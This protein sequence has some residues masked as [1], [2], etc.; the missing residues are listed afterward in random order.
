MPYMHTV[1]TRSV[2]QCV[3][4]SCSVSQCNVRDAVHSYCADAQITSLCGQERLRRSTRTQLQHTATHCNPLHHNA[5]HYN[6]LRHTATHC[7]TLH[8]TATHCTTLHHTAPHCTT[9]HRT[10]PHCT[11][12]H[13]TAQHCH[14]RRSPI[15]QARNVTT[16]HTNSITGSWA[17]T[18]ARSFTSRPLG[19]ATNGWVSLGHPHWEATLLMMLLVS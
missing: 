4:V 7:N 6:T 19:P 10:A 2:L 1:L 17:T 8:H 3:A 12:L 13:C 11:A 18:S 9:L 16:Q 15:L 14:T 5:P